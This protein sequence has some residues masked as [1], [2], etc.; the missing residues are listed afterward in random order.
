MM[1][2]YMY[3]L[4]KTIRQKKRNSNIETIKSEESYQDTSIL[5]LTETEII[6]MS[7]AMH[8]QEY[9]VATDNASNIQ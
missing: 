1:I 6:K 4:L 7:W 5:Q 8:W 2:R 3:E 9:I